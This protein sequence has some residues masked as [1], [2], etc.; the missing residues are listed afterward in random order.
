MSHLGW[1]VR[2]L[3]AG[4]DQLGHVHRVPPVVAVVSVHGHVGHHALPLLLV[5][6]HQLPDL[7]R[8]RHQASVGQVQLT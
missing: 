3:V 5:Q 8:H 2:Y 6:F 7:V 4:Q 1:Y